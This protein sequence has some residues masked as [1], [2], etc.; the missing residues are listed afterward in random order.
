M[1]KTTNYLHTPNIDDELKNF[2]DSHYLGYTVCFGVPVY[3][4]VKACIIASSVGYRCNRAAYLTDDSVSLYL[5]GKLVP[6]KMS[7]KYVFP[8]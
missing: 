5:M 3:D 2:I 8:S 4:S 7:K 6:I 1:Q